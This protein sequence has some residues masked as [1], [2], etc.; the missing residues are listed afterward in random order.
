MPNFEYFKVYED[1]ASMNA[2]IELLREVLPQSV[3][4]GFFKDIPVLD[5]ESDEEID[6]ESYGSTGWTLDPTK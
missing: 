6:F 4:G 2:E 1:V 3:T 5:L